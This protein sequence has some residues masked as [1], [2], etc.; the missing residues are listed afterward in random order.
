MSAD[1]SEP[2]SQA[3]VAVAAGGDRRHLLHNA[4]AAIDRLQA[5]LDAAEAAAHEPIAIVGMACRLPGGVVD[6]AGYWKVLSEGLDMVGEIPADRWDVDAFYDPNPEAPGKSRT[7]AGGFLQDIAGFEPTFFGISPRE[8]RALDPQQRLLLEV[9]WE[10]LEDAGIA[11]DSLDSTRTG[12]FVGITGTDYSNRIDVEDPARSD[13]YLATGTALNAAAGRVSFTL[14]LQGPCMAIDT[15]CSSSLVAIHTACQSLR[16]GESELAVAGGVNVMMSPEA[17]VMISKWG[18]LS[19]DGR[20]KA[21]DASANGFVRGEGCGLVVLE[22]LS[23]ARAKGRNVLALIRGS[24]INQDGHSSGLTV[25]NGIAQQAVLRQALAAARLAP[26]D[27]SYVEAHG[28]GTSLGDPIEVEAL[29]AVYSE[30]RDAAQPL[31]VGSVKSNLAHLEAASGVTGMM[32]VVLALQHRQLPASLHVREPSPAIPWDRMPVRVSTRLHDWA[33]AHGAARRAGVSAFGFSGVNA[34]AILEEVTPAGASP[35]APRPLFV[36]P[37]SGRSEAA[38]GD[39]ARRYADHLEQLGTVTPEQ[40]ADVCAT[41][42]TGRAHFVHRLAVVGPDVAALVAQLRAVGPDGEV[43][44]AAAPTIARGQAA[45]RVRTAFLFTGQG[46]QYVGM[47]RELHDTEPVF[48]AALERCAAVLD[49]SLP[50]PL[51]QLLFKESAGLLDQTGCTQP[52]LYAL[53]VALAA[54]WRSWG[55]EPGAVI[56]HSVGE[57]AAAAVAGVFSI[58][59][60]ARLIAARGRLMQALPAGGVMVAVQGEAGQLAREVAR[61]VE[62]NA[63][64]MS[65]AARNAPGSWVIAG[66]RA[67][68]EGAAARLAALGL[69]TQGLAVSHAFH[70]P[71]MAPMVAEFRRVAAGVE[72]AQPQLNWISSL[73]GRTLEWSEWAARMPEYWCRH[74]REAVDFE[75]G[76]KALAGA[77]MQ[78]CVEIGPH[79]TLIGLAQQTLGA[80]ATAGAGAL[81]WHASLRRQ[82]S[83]I[84]TIADSVARLHVRGGRID[85]AAY[86]RR[87]ERRSVRLPSTPFQ[88]QHYLIDYR[89]PAR[90]AS[91][92]SGRPVHE[93]LGAR[94]PVAGVAAAFERALNTGNPAWVVD[95]RIGGEAVM[96]LTAYLEISLAAARQVHGSALS[97]IEH[98]EVGEPMV[99]R[100][101]EERLMQVLVDGEGAAAA[102]R[103]RVFSRDAARAESPWTLHASALIGRPQADPAPAAPDLAAARSRC[104]TAVDIAAFYEQ[105]RSRGA[106]FGASFNVMRSAVGGA[107]EGLGEVEADPSVQ[108]EGERYAFHPALLD[109]CFHAS[110]VAIASLPGAED[111]RMYLS[112]GVERIRWGVPPSG[113]LT[114]HAAVR[115][116]R[117]RGDMLLIDITIVDAGGATVMQVEGLRCRRA[118]RDMFRQRADAQ[119]ADWL[120]AVAWHSQPL[121]AAEHG[122]QGRWLVLDEGQGRGERV[123]AEI[124]RRGGAVTRVVAGGTF[125]AAAPGV[126]E[127]DP[128]S[129]GDH[130]RL[131]DNE[132]PPLA[133]IVSLWPLAVPALRD[134]EDLPSMIQRMGT[135]AALLLLQALAAH[136]QPTPLCFVTAGTE[137]VDGSETLCIEQA[138]LAG[139]ARV[140]ALEHPELRVTHVDLDPQS[141]PTS[142]AEA[143]QLADELAEMSAA[144]PAA[145]TGHES[146]V[147]L[148]KGVRFVAR[149]AR[150]RRHTAPPTDEAPT[151]LHIQERGTL[152]NLA[153]AAAERR[154]PGPAEIEIR[155]RASGLNFRDVLSALGLYPG[156]IERLGSDCAGEIVALGSEVRGF[157]LGD[158]VVAMVSGAFASHATTRWEFVAPLPARLDFEL[159]AAIPTA[160]L[161]ADITLN[162]I[163]GMKAGERVLIHSGAGGVGMAAIALA[164]RAGAEIFATAGSPDK[165]AVLARL[166]VQHVLDSRSPAFAD[167]VMRITGGA[168]VNIV[169]NSL[170]GAM[171]DRSFEVLAPDGIFLEIGK[172]NLWTHEQ[173]AALDRGIRYHV[174]DCNDHARDTPQMVGRI[175]ARVLKEIE[176]GLLPILPCTTFAFEQA[177]EAF[178][179]MAQARHTGRVVFRHA[180][181]PRRPAN[182]V[183]DDATYL[184]T[185]GLRGLGLLAAAWLAGEGARHL[186]LAGR[187]APDAQAQQVIAKLRADGASVSVVAADVATAAG[188][189]AVMRAVL[190]SAAPLG[191]VLHGAAVL[192]DGMLVRQSRERLAA[193]MAPKADGAWRLHRALL[194]HGLK[195]DFFAMY[196]S[197]SAVLGSAGQGNYVAANAFLDALT[198]HRR[199]HDDAA[200]SIAWGAWKDVGMAARGSTVDRAAAMGLSSLTPAQGHQALGLVLREGFAHVAVTPVDWPRLLLQLGSNA[201]PPIWQELVAQARA[202]MG[203]A[204]AEGPR[205]AALDFAALPPAERL[206]QL[207][208]LVRR[209]LATVLALPDGGRSLVDDQPFSSFG[210]DSLTSVELRN[211]LQAAVRR[212]VPATAAF[213]WPTTAALAGH[214][215]GYFADAGAHQGD[216]A[217]EELTL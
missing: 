92:T 193:V 10:A 189:D 31:E 36:L 101:D 182:A 132:G 39:V 180:V 114:S 53:Q 144:P 80:V 185:G 152:E 79:P 125:D 170:T 37:L 71:L 175:F 160:Y 19:P 137:A 29:A 169:L 16:N 50:R 133:G 55:V 149:L 28:T 113:R 3:G 22:R 107:G 173:V 93:L 20:C 112:I 62:A 21:F 90:R 124:V 204:H 145:A 111:E 8:A 140:A 158:R 23:V 104:T 5:R 34:H 171:L 183:R 95:H 130:R 165:R 100:P 75:A 45:A 143:R 108:A 15:A 187:S 51:L 115:A 91:S 142:S 129:P 172:R 194:R 141:S 167:E 6:I 135:E 136:G 174:V 197:M 150:Q 156:E 166:G 164:R 33:P 83:G 78:A 202:G 18:M 57:F 67:A 191:G 184:V 127:I 116:P 47:G 163:A 211:R 179:Y 58:E 121:A 206:A 59:D 42:A 181:V 213:E 195:P 1:R 65:I 134:D 94:I 85:W 188:I 86:T 118:S 52:A 82:R 131:L 66:A 201:A 154:P 192:D 72:H 98:V 32:K 147:A 69:R 199:V 216:E 46:S 73:T 81:T 208:A 87:G 148:R 212:P 99:L 9:T 126:V 12:V 200:C 217:R 196:S 178:R 205:A 60:G 84:E 48:R 49:A 109:A 157:R 56:G 96:P 122:L 54:L 77:G 27:V 215:A 4:L 123:A 209:E 40:L 110:A 89:K 30:G 38:L 105:A 198:H 119:A 162:E 159:G 7:K 88:R 43:A 186:V 61:E 176:A 14:G 168:G 103:V 44:A 13:I 24:A 155:V 17:Y 68:V 63:A 151:R 102:T 11:P 161:T 35:P 146:R 76:V 177:A 214:L 64:E 138:P 210:L 128:G 203:A 41:A 106:D 117:T 2:S 153:I 207:V 120:Y 97:T 139:L 74:V 26:A 25:P 70:S 190:D